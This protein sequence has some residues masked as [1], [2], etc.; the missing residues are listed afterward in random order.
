M[1]LRALMVMLVALVGVRRRL[2]RLLRVRLFMFIP[3]ALVAGLLSITTVREQPLILMTAAGMVAV[4][5]ITPMPVVAAVL[6]IFAAMSSRCLVHRR[7]LA[8]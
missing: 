6:P 7:Q 2:F 3:V 4:L 5:A 8:R 1:V